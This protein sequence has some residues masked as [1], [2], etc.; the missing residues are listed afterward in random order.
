[1]IDLAAL[2]LLREHD[3]HGY[4][5]RKRITELAGLRHALS[6]GSLYPALNRLETSGAVKAVD[7]AESSWV[8][9]TIPMTGS[10][11]GEASAFVARRRAGHNR[12]AP[13]KP[14][15][16]RRVYGI[17]EVGERT[18]EDLLDDPATDERDFSLKV[19]FCRYLAPERRLALFERRRAQLK[20]Q[21]AAEP[22]ARRRN[23]RGGEHTERIDRYLRSLRDHEL[24]TIGHEIA[25]LTAL[26]DLER[27]IPE[28]VV[29]PHQ[30]DH[31]S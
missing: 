19:A 10:L 13:A 25:W 5:L 11:A 8:A 2:G 30:G 12:L 16:N 26:I 15:R 14:G 3:L 24:D 18:L 6:F 29:P 27:A 28:S 21:V 23:L 9:P 7:A 4:E 31:H 20:N 17:T 1:M 22:H